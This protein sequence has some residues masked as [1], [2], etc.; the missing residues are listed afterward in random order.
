MAAQGH[1]GR[2]HCE[3]SPSSAYRWTACP[4]SVQLLR[5]VPKGK[6]SAYADEG[7]AAH[8]F[9]ESF[10]DA[11]ALDKNPVDYVGDELH[12]AAGQKIVI[13]QDF[14]E[15]VQVYV[16]HCRGLMLV[17]S[18]EAV[19]RPITL[20]PIDPPAPMFGTADFVAVVGTTLH[21]VDLKFGRG[22]IVEAVGN[23]QALYYALGAFL[24]L[25]PDRARPLRE[26]TIT[27]VQPRAEHRDGHVRSW[28]L[29]VEELLDRAIEL[30]D[31]A[32]RALAPGAPLVAGKHCRFC[33]AQGVC[34]EASRTAL[35]VARNEFGV[36][37][38]ITPPAPQT[39]SLEQIAELMGKFGDV[40]AW[41][42]SV[43]AYA[44]EA[45]ERGEKIPGWKLVEKRANRQWASEAELKS[46][47]EQAGVCVYSD[48]EVMSPVQ[49]ERSLGKANKH[50]F[51][52]ELVVKRSSGLSLAPEWD[53]RPA[54]NAVPAT[55]EFSAIEQGD[56]CA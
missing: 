21:V 56:A 34:P 44:Q 50:L 33:A 35:E 26:V 29:P 6:S 32:K 17:A 54:V 55:A 24:T 47:G 49:L 20:E 5:R 28:T 42:N 7:T 46:W 10:L 48:P 51:P 41:M 9:A 2:L 45:A 40:E 39:L 11:A 16:D 1:A 43:R 25:D 18:W 15:A 3:L 37:D 23:L 53:K 27:I 8:E 52:A 36:I 31:S 30:F 12:T 4:G 22:V 19:E 38:T 13:D 14:A